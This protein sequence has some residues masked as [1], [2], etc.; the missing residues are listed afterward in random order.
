MIALRLVPRGVV[1]K[2]VINKKH[3]IPRLCPPSMVYHVNVVY[4]YHVNVVYATLYTTLYAVK[5]P[6]RP[7]PAAAAAAAA[8]R[9]RSALPSIYVITP[10]TYFIL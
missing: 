6:A 8:A 7:P 9:D 5:Y 10:I 4:V 1:K 3:G 2:G